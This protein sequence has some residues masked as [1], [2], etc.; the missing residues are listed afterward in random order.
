MPVKIALCCAEL[1]VGSITRRAAFRHAILRA[2][3]HTWDVHYVQQPVQDVP[4][5]SGLIF[6]FSFASAIKLWSPFSFFWHFLQA[7][8]SFTLPLTLDT[9]WG[10]SPFSTLDAGFS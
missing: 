8:I 2:Q 9:F 4:G 10:C 7:R 5:C 1:T 6:F 3:I